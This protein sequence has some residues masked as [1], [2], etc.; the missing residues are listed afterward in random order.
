MSGR[1]SGTLEILVFNDENVTNLPNKVLGHLKYIVS[2]T[3]ITQ[4]STKLITV[5]DAVVDES[6]PLVETT[7]EYLVIQSDQ[8]ISIK[9][10]SSNDSLEIKKDFPFILKGS[11]TDLKVSNASGTAA[12]VEIMSGS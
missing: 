10:N 2:D 12:N 3:S 4:W 8:D 9:L 5:A 11:V 1:L 6:V 7:V